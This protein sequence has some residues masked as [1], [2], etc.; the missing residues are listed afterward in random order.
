MIIF[1]RDSRIGQDEIP[2]GRLGVGKA[3]NVS[4]NSESGNLLS[5]YTINTE[6][7]RTIQSITERDLYVDGK[8]DPNKNLS[9]SQGR[10]LENKLKYFLL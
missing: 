1:T 4:I 9:S 7:L 2:A 5:P 8:H 3:T 10:S 6:Y